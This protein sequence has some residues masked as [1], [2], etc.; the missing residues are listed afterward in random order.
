VKSPVECFAAFFL[1]L[2]VKVTMVCCV[3][4]I[5]EAAVSECYWVFNCYKMR[6]AN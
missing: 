6:L 1:L 4:R 2:M 3:L 5:T